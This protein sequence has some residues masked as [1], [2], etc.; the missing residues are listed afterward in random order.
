MLI[1]FMEISGYFCV[2]LFFVGNGFFWFF[3]IFCK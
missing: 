2:K 1:N 3:D